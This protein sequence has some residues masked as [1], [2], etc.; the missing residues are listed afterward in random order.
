MRKIFFL[1]HEFEGEQGNDNISELFQ[2][3]ILNPR[4][5]LEFLLWGLSP[6]YLSHEL[7]KT[8]R[9]HPLRK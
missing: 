5:R 4:T 1:G 3:K 6:M 2:I 7:V 8:Q 9:E